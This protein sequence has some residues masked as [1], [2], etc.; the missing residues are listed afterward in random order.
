MIYEIEEYE[1]TCVGCFGLLKWNKMKCVVCIVVTIL[2]FLTLMKYLSVD[3]RFNTTGKNKHK[4]HKTITWQQWLFLVSSSREV[5]YRRMTSINI[6]NKKEWE[7]TAGTSVL[8]GQ[9]MSIKTVSNYQNWYVLINHYYLT[10]S[11]VLLYLVHAKPPKS[12]KVIFYYLVQTRFKKKVIFQD[13]KAEWFII[14]NIS[15]AHVFIYQM[16][17]RQRWVFFPNSCEKTKL[18]PLYKFVNVCLEVFFRVCPYCILVL[19]DSPNETS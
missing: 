18:T 14:N 15:D 12:W 2:E 8:I 7:S 1:C 3:T 19:C 5:Q 13:F 10:N 4:G 6:N 17:S 11:E 16:K 9:K